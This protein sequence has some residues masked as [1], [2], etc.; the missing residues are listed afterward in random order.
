MTKKKTLK[1]FNQGPG[2]RKNFSVIESN[3]T[4]F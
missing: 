3:K 4:K 2:A 1:K